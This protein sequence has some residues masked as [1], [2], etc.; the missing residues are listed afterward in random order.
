MRLTRLLSAPLLVA[1]IGFACSG[2]SDDTI[3]ANARNRLDPLVAAIRRDVEAA[4]RPGAEQALTTL[5]SAVAD[6]HRQGAIGGVRAAAIL[7]AATQVDRALPLT[8]TTTTTTTTP[9]APPRPPKPGGGHDK[10]DGS[11][12]N[13]Q[14]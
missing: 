8:P 11:G 6:L 13:S 4:D 7:A 1:L 14:G 12:N 5:R 9:P 2:T 10:G 3:S